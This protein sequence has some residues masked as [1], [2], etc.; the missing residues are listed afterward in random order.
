MQDKSSYNPR[1]INSASKLS[2]C[3]PGEKSKC[4][5]TLPVDNIQMEI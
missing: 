3:I 1:I 5:L 2:G 4:I